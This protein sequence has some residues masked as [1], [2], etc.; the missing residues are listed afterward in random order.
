MAKKLK[1]SVSETLKKI[2]VSQNI[3]QEELADRADLDRT[4][5]SGVERGIRN[6]TLESL[7][8]IVN[9]LG[10]ELSEF[11]DLLKIDITAADESSNNNR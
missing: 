3:S 2:R 1:E 10:I 7:E 4:Y 9:G 8:S 11:I 5:I 6:I